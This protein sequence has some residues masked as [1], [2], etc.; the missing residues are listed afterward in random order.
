MYAVLYFVLASPKIPSYAKT[1]DRLLED[2]FK[3]YQKWVRPVETLNGT[4]RVKFGLAISQLVDV[5]NTYLL[6]TE[7]IFYCLLFGQN[8][9]S[10]CFTF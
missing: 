8:C 5:V 10:R 6:D 1:E 7:N 4:I 9:S 2:L 3:K